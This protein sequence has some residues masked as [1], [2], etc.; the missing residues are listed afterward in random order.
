MTL[1]KNTVE[2]AYSYF[3]LELTSEIHIFEG[4][5]TLGAGCN[6]RYLSICEKISRKGDNS[7]QITVCLNEDEARKKAAS[8]G[9]IVCG[10]CVSHLYESYE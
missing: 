9:R 6:L 4:E 1:Q 5:F 8:I 7:K 3:E 10:T 2:K